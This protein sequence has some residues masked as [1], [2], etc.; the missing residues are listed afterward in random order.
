LLNQPPVTPTA[1]AVE[2]LRIPNRIVGVPTER[3][4]LVGVDVFEILDVRAPLPIEI[5]T[6]LAA[7]AIARFRERAPRDTARQI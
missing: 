5:G 2:G 7:N 1:L 4:I 6:K 3:R